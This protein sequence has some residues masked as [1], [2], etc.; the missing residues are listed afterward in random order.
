M[1]IEVAGRYTGDLPAGRYLTV[2]VRPIPTDPG[3]SYWVQA[4]PMSTETGWSSQPVSIGLDHDAGRG[5]TFRICAVAASQEYRRGQQL[6]ALPEG[7]SHCIDV[8][9][10]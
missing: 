10:R 2:L 7:P 3:Q 4:I 5:L 1:E 9:R 6:G 8:T